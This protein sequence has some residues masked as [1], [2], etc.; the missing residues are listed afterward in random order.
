VPRALFARPAAPNWPGLG[1]RA[2]ASFVLRV[3][4]LM[5]GGGRPAPSCWREALQ[6]TVAAALLTPAAA[7]LPCSALTAPAG[8]NPIDNRCTEG[9]SSSA[10]LIASGNS[11]SG[12]PAAYRQRNYQPGL[13]DASDGSNLADGSWTH[14]DIGYWTPVAGSGSGATTSVCG[15]T[16]NSGQ[17]YARSGDSRGFSGQGQLIQVSQRSRVA[18]GC[19]DV[20]AAGPETGVAFV[21]PGSEPTNPAGCA[22]GNTCS[23]RTRTFPDDWSLV[24]DASTASWTVMSGGNGAVSYPGMG[25]DSCKLAVSRCFVWPCR[26][27]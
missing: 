8:S 12:W 1:S 16:G 10:T 14:L 20:P 15:G 13:P 4:G 26:P 9:V 22:G 24:S 11:N 6:L 23:P 25:H 18:I 5:R 21:T 3:G 19:V 27:A 17:N 2:A 7:Q